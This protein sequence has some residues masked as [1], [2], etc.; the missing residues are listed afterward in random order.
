MGTCRFQIVPPK[1]ANWLLAPTIIFRVLVLFSPFFFFFS[2]HIPSI[3]PNPLKAN[4]PPLFLISPLLSINPPLDRVLRA[5]DLKRIVTLR[6]Q[7]TEQTPAFTPHSGIFTPRLPT[8]S[9]KRP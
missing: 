2:Y 7:L 9:G 3:I 4:P 6:L 1:G 5:D 8:T